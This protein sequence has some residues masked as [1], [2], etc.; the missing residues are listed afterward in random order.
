MTPSQLSLIAET[1]LAVSLVA[2]CAQT[3]VGRDDVP[4]EQ[5]HS[6]YRECGYEGDHGIYHRVECLRVSLE[7]V[8]PPN[9]RL[10][11]DA[12]ASM[13]RASYSAPQSER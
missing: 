11:S 9:S 7:G 5:A 12:S 13:R 3:K 6:G 4:A 10:V 2:A 1:L 8:M